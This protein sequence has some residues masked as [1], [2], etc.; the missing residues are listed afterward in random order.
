MFRK[1]TVGI[2]TPS[3]SGNVGGMVYDGNA[4]SGGLVGWIY[5]SRI[6][7]KFGRIGLKREPD[8]KL[9]L[10]VLIMLDLLL[11]LM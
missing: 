3:L 10:L 4:A 11:R 1:Y 9:V 7:G 6:M 2:A 8:T 5:T